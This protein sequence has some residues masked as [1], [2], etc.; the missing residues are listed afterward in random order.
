MDDY[1]ISDYGVFSE[2]ISTTNGL[3][4]GVETNVTILNTCRSELGGGSIFMGPICDSC[5]SGFDRLNNKISLLMENLGVISN[6]FIS[7]AQGYQNG[8]EKASNAILNLSSGKLAITSGNSGVVTGNAN[9]DAIYSYL[10]QQGFNDAAICGILANIQHESNFNPNAVGDGGTSYGIC[11]WH[12]E[13]NT[14]L[15]NYCNSNGLDYRTVEGQLSY[16]MYELKNNYTGVYNTL[17]SVPNTQQGAYQ[18]AYEWTVK[19]ERPQNMESAG[20]NRGNTAANTY[21]STYGS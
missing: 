21:W 6:Y 7:V 8:D 3:K 9:Q 12:N 1:S 15:Q 20:Q 5:I 13:R 17:K 14:S 2:A 16:L 11:Q 10:S 19:F 18:A 4:S